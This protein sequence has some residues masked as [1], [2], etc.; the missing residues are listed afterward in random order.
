MKTCFICKH[1]E[2]IPGNP[3][4]YDEPPSDA[5]AHCN[6]EESTQTEDMVFG[7][8]DCSNCQYFKEIMETC[9]VCGAEF[10]TSDTLETSLGGK[11]CSEDCWKVLEGFDFPKPDGIKEL[12][13]TMVRR[14]DR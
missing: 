3:W 12:A 10:P 1:S 4:G 14:G 11:C 13:E 9:P 2:I 8:E 7:D 6:L 5:E